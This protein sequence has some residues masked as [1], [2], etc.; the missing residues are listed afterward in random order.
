[1]TGRARGCWAGLAVGVAALVVGALTV[2]AW[3]S[4]IVEGLAAKDGFRGM[5][6]RQVGGAMKV[7]GEFAELD[8]KDW[9]VRTAHFRSEGMPGEAIEALEAE[10]ITGKFDP[11]GVL[12]RVWRVDWV[13]VERARIALRMP[14][15]AKK[16]VKQKGR[17]PPWAVLMPD[18]FSCGPIRCPDAVME[19][20]FQGG[21]A[22]LTNLAVTA[23]LIGRDFRYHATN[24]FL[25]FPLFPPM[26]VEDLVI[27]VT[28]PM[29]DVEQARL[30][31]SAPGDPAAANLKVRMGMREDK[32]VKAD[33]VLKRMPIGQAMPER[34]RG[35]LAGRASGRMVWEND[36]TGGN[37][38]S[39]GALSL[40]DVRLG[41][42]P[43]LDELARLHS[44]P[45][46]K[47]FDFDKFQC[48]FFVRTNLFWAERLQLA[49]EGKVK[50]RGDVW[51]LAKEQTGGVEM[52]LAEVP[53]ARWLP[54][55]AKPRVSAVAGGWFRWT[56]R[57]DNLEGSSGSALLETAGEIRNPTGLKSLLAPVGIS[58]P[59]FL[60][61]T[62]ARVQ[63]DYAGR[64]FEV[65]D[66]ALDAPGFIHLRAKGSWAPNDVLELDAAVG[67]LEFERWLP[68]AARSYVK[69]SAR[70]E[71]R[72]R[73]PKLEFDRGDGEV[74][75]N[76]DGM[77][78]TDVKILRQAAR[79]LKDSGLNELRFQR[80]RLTA[81]YRRGRITL[82]DIDFM[83][84]GKLGV[85][86]T[87]EIGLRR[88]L[89]GGL[90][91][92]LAPKNVGWLPEAG[93]GLFSGR[94]EN[95]AWAPVRLAG[96]LKKPEQDFDR[97]V[98]SEV[99]GSPSTL[100]WLLMKAVSW[101]L[102]DWLGT[103]PKM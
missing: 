91:V 83:S 46:L 57:P 71:G 8:L 44:N 63:L 93:G 85:R 49:S 67:G 78:V 80:A 26:R 54:E 33:V 70:L 30:V 64:V 18:R 59:D 77:R 2:P 4:G 21:T 5:L 66:L 34:L 56:G 58:V 32:S 61:V 94:G 103:A 27:F 42:L 76:L 100:V 22:S 19:F 36:P 53:L 55:D 24:G 52:V 31:A 35:R 39:D 96:T 73:C 14:D 38:V 89:S 20:P 23:E 16:I 75:L 72:W 9:R 86:G 29:I 11:A 82:R 51:Y 99:K 1:M 43:M 40:E 28:R 15:D 97:R 62:N 10:G 92:G 25:D 98:L 90:E 65:R 79:F 95:L 3:L 41:N 45:E 68:A 60:Q 101:V 69:G 87:V 7:R 102:G 37:I 6:S 48:K 13:D 81:V 50:L 74:R 17:R 88:E 12:R 84:A 47:Q